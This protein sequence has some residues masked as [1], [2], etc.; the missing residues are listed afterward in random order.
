MRFAIMGS[1]G[2]GCLFGGFLARAGVDVTL[3]ARGA[4]LEALRSTG[5]DVQ[6]LN[7]ECFHVEIRATDDPREVG[8][9]EASGGQLTERIREALAA[10]GIN[11]DASPGVE[12]DL[13]EKFLFTPAALGYT[14]LTRLSVGQALACPEVVEVMTRLT[15]EAEAVGRAR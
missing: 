4:N 9:D 5:L 11:A 6:L 2:L 10:A 14:T 12:L 7:G 13:W 8:P 15:E 1:G 3:I